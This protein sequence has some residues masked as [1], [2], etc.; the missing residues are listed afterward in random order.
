MVDIKQ[1]KL[2]KRNLKNVHIYIY[3]LFNT[4]FCIFSKKDSIFSQ[5][6]IKQIQ[7]SQLM[8]IFAIVF[9]YNFAFSIGH[10]VLLLRQKIVNFSRFLC[11]KF[12]FILININFFKIFQKQ[13]IQRQIVVIET[14]ENWFGRV[15]CIIGLSWIERYLW[16]QFNWNNLNGLVATFS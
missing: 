8:M 13:I 6:A 7:K 5:N 14:S 4:F 16:G 11:Q 12:I 10:S 1:K 9:L 15:H 2:H 3:K